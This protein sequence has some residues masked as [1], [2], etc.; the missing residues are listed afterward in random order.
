M[1]RHNFKGQG[2]SHGNHKK[3]RAPGSIGACATPA[4]VFKGMKMAGQFGNARVTTLNLEVVEGDAERDL[5]L[6]KGAVPGPERR[7]RVRAQRGEGGGEGDEPRST[8]K[9]AD[10]R[11]RAARSS[12]P[13]TI[14]GIEPNVAV[15]HQV[16]TAQLAAA[17]AGTHS[18]KTRAEVRGGGAKPWRQKGTGRARQGSIR[19][20][21]WRGGGVAHGPKP[22]DY[23]AAHA[24]EDGAARAALGAL[25]P[26]GR[27]QGRRRRRLGHRRRPKHQGRASQ[28]LER[29]R[30]AHEGRARPARAARAATAPTKRVWKSFR[31]LGERVQIVLPEELNT[32]DVLVNDWLVFSQ[33]TLDA[34]GRP[35][36]RRGER[37]RATPTTPGR[38]ATPTEEAT[39]T[40]D[41]RDIII[42]PVVSEKSYAALDA[43]VYTFVVAP[44]ANKIE[45]R[46]A[47]EEIFGVRVA[48]VNTLN[49]KGKRKRNRR[50]GTL[51]HARRHEA[52]HRHPRR[53][54]TASTSSGADDADPQAQADQPRS[55]VPDRLRLRRDHQDQAREVADQAEAAAPVVATRYG[56]MTA[57]HRGGGHKQQ[58]RIVDFRR[59]KDGVP[60]KVA[61]IEYDPNRNA[62]SRC[63]TTSTARSATSSPRTA[64]RSATCCRAVRARRSGPATRCRCATSRSAPRC[65]T[66]S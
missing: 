27:R 9:T 59:N 26:R 3:H 50:T 57:R 6:V 60:A 36:G 65:T 62:A 30:A 46:N 10:R 18:T 1:K 14:F 8:M 39:M 15:M 33:A 63:C 53:R 58:Y 12:C 17:R 34:R 23:R 22:R 4:R 48:K 41:P 13:T 61:A 5:L 44:D 11:R 16:V 31:N 2:A 54:A 64:S 49:R 42:R 38:R 51:R 56:R 28:L 25:R 37:R 21:H 52:G 7:P 29:A 43:N 66:S 55:P 35:L 40:R 32:Y 24:E 20:P 19:S 45:I 47:V